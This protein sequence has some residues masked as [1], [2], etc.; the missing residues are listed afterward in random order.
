M[1]TRCCLL[2]CPAVGDVAQAG[3]LVNMYAK[4]GSMLDAGMSFHSVVRKN[5]LNALAWNAM[6]A[7]HTQ[8]NMGEEAFLLFTRVQQDGMTPPDSATYVCLLQACLSLCAGALHWGKYIHAQIAKQGGN[9]PG[10]S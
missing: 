10:S 4:S 9:E 8:Q 5:A 1:E 6:F 7:S 3:S 2:K